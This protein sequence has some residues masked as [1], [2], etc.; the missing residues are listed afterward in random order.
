MEGCWAEDPEANPNRPEV[1]A[2]KPHLGMTMTPEIKACRQTC[3]SQI[4]FDE[5]ANQRNT[6]LASATD[7]S[8]RRHCKKMSL[9]C[10]NMRTSCLRG[11]WGGAEPDPNPLGLDNTGPGEQ[12]EQ[13]DD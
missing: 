13:T 5:C 3:W 10:R 4:P 11:C 6:C 2:A 9:T 12:V 1:V 8:D 7:K